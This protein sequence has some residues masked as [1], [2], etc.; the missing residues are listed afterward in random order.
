MPVQRARVIFVDDYADLAEMMAEYF[1]DL[2][3]DAQVAL[4]GVALEAALR[5]GLPDLVVL[6]LHMPGR[7]GFELMADLPALSDCGLIILT[8]NADPID[9][10]LGL[11]MGADDYVQKPV[12]LRE[13][14]ARAAAVLR[15]RQGRKGSR[16]TFETTCADLAAARVLL[17]DGATEALSGGEVALI[18]AFAE[19]PHRVLSREALMDMAPAEATDAFD[20]AI[21]PRIARLRRKLRTAWI[22]T[23]RGQGYRFEPPHDT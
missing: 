22:V 5:V 7:S 21:D 23:V 20:R 3:Y 4:G 15:R 6:D 13:L 2:G 12:D 14:A 16:V 10:I 9:R 18:R 1:T 19:N 11:E 17:M 8:G